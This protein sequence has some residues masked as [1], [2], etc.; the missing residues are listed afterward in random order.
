M[1]IEVPLKASCTSVQSDQHPAWATSACGMEVCQT[2]STIVDFYQLLANM[3]KDELEELKALRDAVDARCKE[4]EAG[5]Q[6]DK[7]TESMN[8]TQLPQVAFVD[9]GGKGLDGNLK[10][11]GDWDITRHLGDGRYG[12]VFQAK[13]Q[14]ASNG[15]TH[16]A[17]MISLENLNPEDMMTIRSEYDA[18]KK[19]GQHPCIAGLTGALQSEANVYFFMELAKGKELFDFIKIRQQNST[20]VRQ[21]A[22]AQVA[23]SISSALAHCHEVGICHRDVKPENIIID[24]DYSAKLIDFGCACPRFELGNQ[25][26]G[27]IPFIAPELFLDS[28]SDG[29]PADVWSLAVVLIE[30]LHGLRAIPKALGW[31]KSSTPE[32]ECGRQLQSLFVEPARGLAHVQACLATT[33]TY[34][35]HDKLVSM[36]HADPSQRPTANQLLGCWSVS[37]M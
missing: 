9:D 6:K 3:S 4:L 33:T 23:S 18:L 31:D 2:P 24:K 28:A 19:V 12:K 26:V 22:I 35:G 21:E 17:K 14:A 25:L 34:V 16:V 1:S 37:A 30:M 8:I 11:L 13:S 32:I 20:P 10:R 29:A 27:T 5:A 7:V 15:C 36:L